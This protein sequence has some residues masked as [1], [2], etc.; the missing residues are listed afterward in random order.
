MHHFLR[1]LSKRGWIVT[2]WI[3]V[4]P[5][6]RLLQRHVSESW[7]LR[8]WLSGRRKVVLQGSSIGRKGLRLMFARWWKGCQNLRTCRCAV[9]GNWWRV[10]VDLGAWQ[11]RFCTGLVGSYCDPVGEWRYGQGGRFWRA[12]RISYRH[13]FGCARSARWGLVWSVLDLVRVMLSL[14]LNLRKRCWFFYF[15]LMLA[16]QSTRVFTLD[17]ILFGLS[18]KSLA[19]FISNFCYFDTALSATV[20][21][22]GFCLS[23]DVWCQCRRFCAFS[24]CSLLQY[25]QIECFG[26]CCSGFTVFWTGL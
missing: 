21:H 20:L 4:Y 12:W 7:V 18:V 6:W 5:I 13:V 15:P 16:R 17:Q 14:L 25:P 23:V 24:L 22:Q 8:G 19:S 9:S 26:M 3:F 10:W 11:C 2:P 1:G